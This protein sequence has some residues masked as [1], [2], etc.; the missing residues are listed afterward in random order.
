MCSLV[1]SSLIYGLVLD[2]MLGSLQFHAFKMEPHASKSENLNSFGPFSETPVENQNRNISHFSGFQQHG[3]T[4][5]Q[6]PLSD[7]S[8][9]PQTLY[10]MMLPLDSTHL[11]DIIPASGP[12]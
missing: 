11:T 3:G 10:P 5:Y 2:S 4:R 6:T 9:P 7:A 8:V 1:S 12:F